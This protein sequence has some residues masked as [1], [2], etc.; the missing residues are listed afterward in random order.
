MQQASIGI[1]SIDREIFKCPFS[2]VLL[3]Y[4]AIPLPL[5]ASINP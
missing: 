3:D 4:A 5:N 1:Y 2:H